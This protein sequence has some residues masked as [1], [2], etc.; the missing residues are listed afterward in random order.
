MR[1]IDFIPVKII[2][3]FFNTMS[4]GIETVTRKEENM[5]AKFFFVHFLVDNFRLFCSFQKPAN[6]QSH[7]CRPISTGFVI[8]A[9]IMLNLNGNAFSQNTAELLGYVPKARLLI[10]NAD[11][12][13][14]CHAENAATQELLTNGYI[15]SATIMV[16]C[17]WLAEAAQFCKTHP[18]LDIGIH[19]TFTCEWKRYKWGSVASSDLV[20]SLLTPEGYFPT[21]IQSVEVNAKP[22]EVEREMRAQIDKAI[23]LGIQPTH[24]DNHMGS[25]YGLATGRHFLDIIFKIS[26]EYKLPFR[27]PR[28]LS[29]KYQATLPPERI[30]MINGLVAELVQKGYILPDYL[31]TVEHGEDYESTVEA[32]RRLFGNLKP[33]VTELYIHAAKPSEEMKAISNVWYQRDWDYRIFMDPDT[34]EF[35]DDLGIK[36]IGW[37]ELQD[38]QKVQIYEKGR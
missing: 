36:L 32:Y 35:L 18:D 5:A 28:H 8:G 4:I 38:L 24:L 12:Y 37:R 15:T 25:V 10:V 2:Y 7:F 20:K 1:L 11:D 27:L 23:Q 3:N 9:L 29:E 19:L 6:G 31:E 34:K 33:G 22:E 16:P 26:A 21:D 17:P 30:E 13:G 14:M